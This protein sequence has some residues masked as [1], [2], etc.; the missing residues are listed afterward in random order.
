ME[1][2]D[3]GEGEGEGKGEGEGEGKVERKRTNRFCKTM[4]LGREL[5]GVRRFSLKDRE[6]PSELGGD[7]E[8]R[9]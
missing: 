2:G 7:V 3:E 4:A 1:V 5:V 9:R 8:G 6:R